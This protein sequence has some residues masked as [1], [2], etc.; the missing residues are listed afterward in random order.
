VKRAGEKVHFCISDFGIGI[1]KEKTDFIFERF[2]R[3]GKDSKNFSG[4]GLG[5][6]ITKEIILRHQGEIWVESEPEKGSDFYFML[7][8]M[9]EAQV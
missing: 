2:F 1:P 7:P 4:L 3:I 6:Y 9:Q 8:L 5:L